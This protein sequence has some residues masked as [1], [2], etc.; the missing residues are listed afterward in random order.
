M[1]TTRKTPRTQPKRPGTIGRT[2]P[3]ITGATPIRDSATA[4][5]LKLWLTLARA[6]QAAAE[7]SRVDIGSHGFSLAEFSILEALYSKGP[8]LLGDLQHKALLSSGGITFVVDR[9]ETRGLV[10]RQ[11]CPTDRRAR[12]AAL[13]KEG[14]DVMRMVFPKHAEAMR[15]AMD[16]LSMAE[17]KAA[18][19]LLK[20]L[21]L[22]AARKS[23]DS[24]G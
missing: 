11:S 18:T 10:E 17:Q 21:G 5:A 15:G 3:P 22:A 16:G 6:Y 12:Y 9:L 14:A 20:R 4:T 23:S 8:L 19:S 13:T 2:D 1:S 7:I 24:A